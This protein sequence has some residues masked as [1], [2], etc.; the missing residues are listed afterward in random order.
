MSRP[1]H[2]GNQ[3]RL[4]EKNPI[5]IPNEILSLFVDELAND[6]K[7]LLALL[8]VSRPFNALALPHIYREI[9]CVTPYE[10]RFFPPAL[11]LQ[12]IDTNPGLQSTRGFGF[13]YPGGSS[14]A[15]KRQRNILGTILPYLG[16]LE[17]LCITSDSMTLVEPQAHRLIPTTA[18]L[19]RLRL[20]SP[21][22]LGDLLNFLECQPELESL[23][24][25]FDLTAVGALCTTRL[26]AGALPNLRSL[27]APFEVVLY[28]SART[29]TSLLEF[30][31]NGVRINPTKSLL[32]V[33]IHAV[34]S[35]R[36]ISE[37]DTPDKLPMAVVMASFLRS[38]E[39]LSF[40]RQRV[41]SFL[42]IV[43]SPA[44]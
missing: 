26:S 28:F 39:Y 43:G 14:P 3:K 24:L 27:R 33:A 31:L 10:P 7:T 4:V 17:R 15:A 13:L 16:G 1:Y 20:D 44:E 41:S 36:A 5:E 19:T 9:Y 25:G 29:T 12:G 22:I 18:R 6:H 23:T 34:R 42:R 40:N 38:L 8:F 30:T 35:I 32:K 2:T 37:N 11:L 21:F